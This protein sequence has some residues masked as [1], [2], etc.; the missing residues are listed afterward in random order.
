MMTTTAML[1]YLAARPSLPETDAAMQQA[2]IDGYA[3]WDGAAWQMK[4]RILPGERRLV[5]FDDG[6]TREVIG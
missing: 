2:I 3:R 1:A 4:G 5:R 6:S